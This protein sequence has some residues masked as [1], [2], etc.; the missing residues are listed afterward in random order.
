MSIPLDRI[1]NLTSEDCARL[2]QPPYTVSSGN[3]LYALCMS[4]HENLEKLGDLLSLTVD[5]LQR[6]VQ[7]LKT[8]LPSE[9][10]ERLS[11]PLPAKN[12][13]MGHIIP[14]RSSEDRHET[15]KSLTD[16]GEER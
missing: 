9:E 5:T 8:L 11:Q 1:S 16:P 14:D 15:D 12:W 6:V 13:G 4:Y 7:E 3:D 2:A 10:L